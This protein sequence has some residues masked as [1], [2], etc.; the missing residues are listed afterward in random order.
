MVCALGTGLAQSAA[1]PNHSN[2]DSMRLLHTPSGRLWTASLFYIPA[3]F[4][5][6]DHAER[7]T[8]D[9]AEHGAACPAVLRFESQDLVLDLFDWP[10]DW[11][12]LP[13][14]ELRAL[15]RRAHLAVFAPTPT[16]RANELRSSPGAP[17][18]GLMTDYPRPYSVLRHYS[19]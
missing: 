7:G 12:L 11:M 10:D 6:G 2:P 15:V 19:V 17:S 13:D 8:A 14:D 4:V 9:R 3:A 1:F 18:P 5:A 16:R